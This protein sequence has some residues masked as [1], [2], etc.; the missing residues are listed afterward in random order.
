MLFINKSQTSARR[1]MHYL[2]GGTV[3]QSFWGVLKQVALM[4]P[5][6]GRDVGPLLGLAYNA[7]ARFYC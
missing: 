5:Q 7:T 6:G 1:W 3:M 2:G 4:R